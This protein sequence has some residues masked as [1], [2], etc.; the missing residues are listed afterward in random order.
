MYSRIWFSKRLYIK[1]ITLVMNLAVDCGCIIQ[2]CKS[3]CCKRNHFFTEIRGI[4]NVMY[5]LICT[6]MI[7]EFVVYLFS[8]ASFFYVN[9]GTVK[10]A[11]RIILTCVCIWRIDIT[12]GPSRVWYCISCNW[13]TSSFNA[14]A[15]RLCIINSYLYD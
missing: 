15:I 13:I 5:L 2:K 12:S 11:F 10:F 9:R 1:Y 14:E 7:M 4:K 6:L 3:D 8:Y